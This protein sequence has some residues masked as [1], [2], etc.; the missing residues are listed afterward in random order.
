MRLNIDGPWPFWMIVVAAVALCAGLRWM[1]DDLRRRYGR[2]TPVALAMLL[3][4]AALFVAPPAGKDR[5]KLITLLAAA[6]GTAVL[7][8]ARTGKQRDSVR[9]IS[10][11]ASTHRFTVESESRSEAAETLPEP[12][13]RLPLFR[14]MCEPAT[15]YVLSRHGPSDRRTLVFEFETHPKRPPPR[16]MWAYPDDDR[17]MT[18]IAIGHP[19]LGVPAFE[20]RPATVAARPLEDDPPWERIE[21]TN[22]PRFA[23]VFTLYAQ[24]LARIRP[25]FTSALV[26]ELERDP[27]R[28]LEGLGEW[29]IAYRVRRGQRSWWRGRG[30]FE[31]FP[32]PDLLAARIKTAEHLCGLITGKGKPVSG[33][34][35]PGKMI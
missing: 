26:E 16:W 3:M 21:L 12:L 10:E 5:T 33:Q 34:L 6:G 20:L 13:R 9:A 31:S 25:M 1:S 28:C 7:I 8:I 22:R 30:D 32:A 24:D 29:I 19:K 11:W 2:L 23:A 4:I 27:C 14:R 35:K 18:V 17:H 15:L